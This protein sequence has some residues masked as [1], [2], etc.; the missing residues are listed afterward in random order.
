MQ[1]WDFYLQQKKLNIEK[2]ALVTDLPMYISAIQKNGNSRF[3]Y[4]KG[5][6][7]QKMILI[8]N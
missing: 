3:Q 1:A 8:Y 7:K 6:I 4:L 2:I 5:W